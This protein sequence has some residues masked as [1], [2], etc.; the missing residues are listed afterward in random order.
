MKVCILVCV[1]VVVGIHREASA[2]HPTPALLRED[3]AASQ[4]QND[5]RLR[6]ST[7]AFEQEN[8][9]GQLW[10]L[11][12]LGQFRLGGDFAL[13]LQL[14]MHR[15]DQEDQAGSVG[16]GDVGGGL[17]YSREFDVYQGSLGLGLLLPTGDARAGRG[18]G[19]LAFESFAHGSRRLLDSWSAIL[20]F[21]AFAQAPSESESAHVFIEEQNTAELRTSVGIAWHGERLQAT[22][23]L[24]GTIPLAPGSAR[25]SQYISAAP[26][27]AYRVKRLRLVAFV[28]VPVGERQLDWRTS[29]SAAYRW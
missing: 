22:A 6:L 29:L 14:P 20:S 4:S 23:S 17:V 27:L 28:E 8:S 21:N 10:T 5:L 26:T 12:L 16:L 11:A 13:R 7:V 18:R 3:P 9:K 1:L 25:G 2:H 24:I 15:L 19:A